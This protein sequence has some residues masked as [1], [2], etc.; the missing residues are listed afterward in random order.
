MSESLDTALVETI[1]T[2]G[3][4]QPKIT[5]E[6]MGAVFEVL[7]ISNVSLRDVKQQAAISK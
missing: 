6:E 7:K 3:S 5:D 2:E 1:H 4:G